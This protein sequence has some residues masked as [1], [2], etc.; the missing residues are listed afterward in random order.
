MVP[1][2]GLSFVLT[3]NKRPQKRGQYTAPFWGPWS[4]LGC[5]LFGFRALLLRAGLRAL[6]LSWAGVRRALL[7]MPPTLIPHRR[8]HRMSH[9][10]SFIF[11]GGGRPGPNIDSPASAALELRISRTNRLAGAMPF[12]RFSVSYHSCNFISRRNFVA[13]RY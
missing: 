3:Y 5:R 4:G 6:S 12:S 8:L 9:L 13:D 11:T 7:P 10:L 2:F 1:C